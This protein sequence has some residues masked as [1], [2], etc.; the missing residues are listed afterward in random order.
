EKKQLEMEMEQLPAS[1]LEDDVDEYPVDAIPLPSRE[2]ISFK[3]IGIGYNCR[4]IFYHGKRQIST[5]LVPT[6][7]SIPDLK[8]MLTFEVELPIKGDYREFSEKAAP[9]IFNKISKLD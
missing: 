6:T 2:K 7:I 3:A 8:Y 1:S 5:N 4:L 9:I